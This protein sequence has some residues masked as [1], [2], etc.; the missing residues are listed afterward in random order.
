MEQIKNQK[1]QDNKTDKFKKIK[2]Y[3]QSFQQKR[4]NSTYVDVKTQPEF[5]K[6]G[7]FFSINYMLLKIFLLETRV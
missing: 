2:T 1:I 7:A 6:I 5:V 4:L 3:L